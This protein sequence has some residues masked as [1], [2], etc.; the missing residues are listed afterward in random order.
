MT[1][2]QR[3]EIMRRMNEGMR[4]MSNE[5]MAR[6][7]LEAA[8]GMRNSYPDLTSHQLAQA[9][10]NWWAQCRG[11][12]PVEPIQAPAPPTLWARIKRWMMA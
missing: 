8:D 5:E 10:Q 4:A 6:R 12:V 7:Q 9:S 1:D 3:Q 11:E 2:E